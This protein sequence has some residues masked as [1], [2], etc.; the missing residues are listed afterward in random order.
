[1]A[2]NHAACA[3]EILSCDIAKTVLEALW[4]LYD[5][6]AYIIKNCKDGIVNL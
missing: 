3:S 5:F 1:M 2:W 6:W 4:P